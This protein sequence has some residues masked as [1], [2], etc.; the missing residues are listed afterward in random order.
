MNPVA[1][2]V[3]AND[4]VSRFKRLQRVL[5]SSEYHL[6]VYVRVTEVD[7]IHLLAIHSIS[8]TKASVSIAFCGDGAIAEHGFSLHLVTNV[9]AFADANGKRIFLHDFDGECE[10]GNATSEGD[11]PLE[12]QVDVLESLAA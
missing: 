3:N 4:V 7:R 2:S 9:L 6:P 12:E 1:P 10:V 5:Q 11:Y 8:L